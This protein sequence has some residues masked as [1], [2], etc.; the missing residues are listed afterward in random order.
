MR[1]T[2]FV[3]SVVLLFSL[4]RVIAI[5]AEEQIEF[6]PW[7]TRVLC[8]YGEEATESLCKGI[9]RSLAEA[10]PMKGAHHFGGKYEEIAKIILQR[11]R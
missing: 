2:A 4:F 5:G 6:G 9:N 7:G 1:K 8:I 3:V 11:A 10:V